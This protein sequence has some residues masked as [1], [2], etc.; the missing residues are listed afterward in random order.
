[1]KQILTSSLSVD[2]GWS[3]NAT[4]VDVC[5]LGHVALNLFVLPFSYLKLEK[6]QYLP[7]MFVNGLN[8]LLPMKN[9]KSTAWQRESTQ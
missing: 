4:R 8:E 1:M 5:N 2:S 7:T 3:G 9:P 6:Q